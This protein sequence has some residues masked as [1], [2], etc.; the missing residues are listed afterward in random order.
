M[1]TKISEF[2]LLPKD[3]IYQI[4][5][6]STESIIDLQLTSPLLANRV[7]EYRSLRYYRPSI[8][9]I[10]FYTPINR[11][12][13]D[14]YMSTY[15]VFNLI[16]C[17]VSKG[18]YQVSTYF[19]NVEYD[20]ELIANLKREFLRISEVEVYID[21]GEL[22]MLFYN[23]LLGEM[24]ID[25]FSIVAKY[26]RLLL[27]KDM[28]SLMSKAGVNTV[29][30]NILEISTPESV[31]FLLK[32]ADMCISIEIEQQRVW[33]KNPRLLF[34]TFNL[35]WANVIAEMFKRKLESLSIIQ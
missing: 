28:L 27:D 17:K 7:R 34:G 19:D 26:G 31:R 8:K 4:I 24:E 1:S 25:K 11:I 3:I 35:D 14:F 33:T 21:Q 9:R 5:R 16:K 22:N 29:K 13:V 18:K 23:E 10:L 20:G 6:F 2:E 12:Y 15:R 30:M 32:L